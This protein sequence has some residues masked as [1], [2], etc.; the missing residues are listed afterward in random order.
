MT[1]LVITSG[2]GSETF[3]AIPRVSTG[4]GMMHYNEERA[5]LASYSTMNP[6]EGCHP[7]LMARAGLYYTGTDD[8]V[9]C[10]SCATLLTQWRSQAIDPIQ[11][12][13]QSSPEC[14]HVSG[15]DGTNIAI[16]APDATATERIKDLLRQRCAELDRNPTQVYY[17]ICHSFSE[18]GGVS[19]GEM[20]GSGPSLESSGPPALGKELLSFHYSIY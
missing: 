14:A 8:A 10:Y 18:I 15:E 20:F 3:E 5:R 11:L 7:V 4:P 16:V 19:R 1:E 13:R 2:A 17:D 9:R 12:H 6:L